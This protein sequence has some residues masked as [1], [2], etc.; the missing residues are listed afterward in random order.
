LG[1]TQNLHMAQAHEPQMSPDTCRM[2]HA[3]S[4]ASIGRLSGVGA[5]WDCVPVSAMV[6]AAVPA[7]V[8]RWGLCPCCPDVGRCLSGIYNHHRRSVSRRC[9]GSPPVAAVAR[10]GARRPFWT[11]V[12][13]R[14][15]TA[16]LIRRR[17]RRRRRRRPC[18][19]WRRRIASCARHSRHSRWRRRTGRSRS[20]SGRNIINKLV[21]RSTNTA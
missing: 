19:G 21:H 5:L 9:H 3:P 4:G 12:A 13:R 1:S 14:R 6:G 11:C 10:S 2:L 20:P 18:P 15:S 8:C 17:R 7:A 16:P